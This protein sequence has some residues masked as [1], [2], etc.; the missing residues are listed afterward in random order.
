MSDLFGNPEDRF[1]HNE[2]QLKIAFVSEQ[3]GLCLTWSGNIEDRFPHDEMCSNARN[4]V[5]TGFPTRSNTNQSA[6]AQKM[7]RGLEFRI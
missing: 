6:Q 7:A 5:S 3:T 2:A 4:P 1:S